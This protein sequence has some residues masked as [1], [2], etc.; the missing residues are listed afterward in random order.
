[1]NRIAKLP[2]RLSALLLG[3][4]A[5][6]TAG[7]S[8][9][10]GRLFYSAG[11]IQLDGSQLSASEIQIIDQDAQ[12]NVDRPFVAV[13]RESSVYDEL[14]KTIKT[15]PSRDSESFKKSAVIAAF[16]GERPTAGYSVDLTRLRN[17]HLALSETTPPKGTMLAQIVTSPFRIYLVSLSDPEAQ[18]EL[19]LSGP[20]KQAGQ[21]FEL[22]AGEFTMIGG[23]AGRQETFR[24][25]GSLRFIRLG[26]IASIIFAVESDGATKARSLKT[27]G[28]GLINSNTN[29]RIPAFDAG[30]LINPPQPSL[31]ATGTL[32]SDNSKLT[33]NLQSTASIVIADGYVGHGSLVSR[34]AR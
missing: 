12:S 5:I 14:R 4:V 2:L 31:S 29:V 20:W 21:A 3:S 11:A 9:H 10:D 33:L 34:A 24:L 17:G 18:I 26:N 16:L 15:L 22:T 1:M 8:Q 32:S 30:T 13:I 6:A 7:M 19:E 28:T 25:A 23:F 27:V